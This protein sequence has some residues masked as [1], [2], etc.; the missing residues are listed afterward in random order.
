LEDGVYEVDD[1]EDLGPQQDAPDGEPVRREDPN[2]PDAAD[3]PE[4][5]EVDGEK[6]NKDTPLRKLR[7]ALKLCGLPRGKNKH[8]AW[9]RLVIHHQHFAENFGVEL[10]RR[11]FQ[12]RQYLEGGDGVRAQSIRTVADQRGAPDP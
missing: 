2:P 5:I 9:R 4:E 1:D 7:E 12:R 11:E 10:A 3:E 8:D 6:F